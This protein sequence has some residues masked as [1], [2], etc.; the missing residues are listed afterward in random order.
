MY[1]VELSQPAQTGDRLLVEEL[2]DQVHTLRLSNNAHR[3]PPSDAPLAEEI[4][5][6]LEI[7]N[8][9]TQARNLHTLELDNLAWNTLSISHHVFSNLHTLHLAHCQSLVDVSPFRNLHT[10]AIRHCQSLVDVSPL[11]SIVDLSLVD[12][13]RLSDI[14]P[15]GAQEHLDLSHCVSI[16]DVSM[17]GR[18]QRLNLARC[19][20]ISDVSALGGVSDLTLSDCPKISDVSNLGHVPKLN[21][22]RCDQIPGSIL[23]R[24]F[25]SELD[26]SYCKNLS[27]LP[28]MLPSHLVK[29][30][31][32]GAEVHNLEQVH[33]SKVSSLQSLQLTLE[34]HQLELFSTLAHI[35]ELVLSI[36]PNI[37]DICPRTRTVSSNPKTLHPQPIVLRLSNHHHHRSSSSSSSSSI[38]RRKSLRLIDE[39]KT[40]SL[41]VDLALGRMTQ[42]ILEH[43]Q[44]LEFGSR[45]LDIQEKRALVADL[46][47]EE[48][49]LI[50][51]GDDH[52]DLS[53]FRHLDR[54]ELT[55][56]SSRSLDVSSLGNLEH[57]AFHR[58]KELRGLGD[59]QTLRSVQ[60][61][62]NAYLS[63]LDL[64]AWNSL[65]RVQLV[66]CPKLRNIDALAHVYAL[67]V[68]HCRHV[69]VDSNGAHHHSL[70]MTN[71]FRDPGHSSNNDFPAVTN[72]CV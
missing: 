16:S 9:G 60:C 42:L 12:C 22:S 6:L 20:Q 63:D 45:Q 33:W 14:S 21:L 46:V 11:A 7:P 13:T 27:K 32:L 2:V 72:L 18:V 59:L 57:V 43:W 17:L 30:H 47:S 70:N 1:E 10:L 5:P 50:G 48:V 40:R 54:V 23:S 37:H 61:S 29:L 68:S 24:H 55:R 64:L 31:L 62:E 66:R 49:Q 4:H 51:C 39:S 28:K 15:L 41:V 19:W 26:L 8:T 3:R 34:E 71:T 52:L 53:V 25:G 36:A 35:P 67:D 58:C 69:K 65:E 56:C 44:H 38:P